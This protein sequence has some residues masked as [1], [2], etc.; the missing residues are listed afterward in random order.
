MRYGWFSE[1]R[2]CADINVL[3]F[4]GK[5]HP[6]GTNPFLCAP[7][8]HDVV[9]GPTLQGFC[10]HRMKVRAANGICNAKK[11]KKKEIVLCVYFASALSMMKV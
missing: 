5:T 11:K 3:S 10:Y 2:G 6:A 8:D 7:Y 1:A 4:I 9:Q